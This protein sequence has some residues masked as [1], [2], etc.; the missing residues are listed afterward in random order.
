MTRSRSA[1]IGATR[2]KIKL[3]KWGGLATESSACNL[4]VVEA[5]DLS[6]RFDMTR[7]ISLVWFVSTLCSFADSSQLRQQLE[8]SY[9]AWHSAIVRKDARAWQRTTAPHRQMEVRNRI[10]SE[11]RPFPAAV[12]QLPAP[13]PTIDGLNFL[14]ANQRGSTA[15]AAYFGKVDFKTGDAPTDNLL[16]LAFVKGAGGWLYDRA[17]FINLAAMPDVR[18]EL[19]AGDLSYLEGT[20]DAR[21]D[22]VVP[23]TA[24]AAPAAKYIAKVYVF[25]P[26]REVNV[27]VNQLSRHRFANAKEA[28]VVIGGARDGANEIYY[29]TRALEGSTGKEA[30]TV[31]VYLMST[32]PGVKPIKAYET[33]VQPGGSVKP[34]D[35]G[36]FEVDEATARKLTGR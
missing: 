7:L 30:M 25:C 29:T 35:R 33:L 32:V 11:Q 15:K 21:P 16:V 2:L 31:R 18:A 14:E 1:P 20:P 27:Q 8:T 12:F 3:I 10:I 6:N 9:R 4:F 28:E 22:G 13:P 36:S 23:P 5:R 17:D 26:G 34:S 19:A 24:A